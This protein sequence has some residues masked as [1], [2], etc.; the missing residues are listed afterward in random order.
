MT[1]LTDFLQWLY[2][3]L[4]PCLRIVGFGGDANTNHTTGSAY[5][6][7]NDEEYDD[8]DNNNNNNNQQY[9]SS[10]GR[11]SSSSNR[12]TLKLLKLIESQYG[13]VHPTFYM[14]GDFKAVTDEAKRQYKILLV[15]LH[16][17][18][19]Q[20][21]PDFCRN[22]LCTE[23]FRDYV[24][25]HFLFYAA[26]ISSRTGFELG[27]N[28]RATTFPFFAVVYVVQSQVNVV[29]RLEGSNLISDID[30][31]MVRLMEL[32]DN[33][34]P[35]LI[36]QQSEDSM[37][38]ETRS[39][40]EEQDLAYKAA[41]ERDRQVAE[42]KK[43]AELEKQRLEELKQRKLREKMERLER[44]KRERQ[45]MRSELAP[46]PEVASNSVADMR[47]MGVS[48]IKFK[49]PDGSIVQ[50]KFDKNAKV[51]QLY[52]FVHCLDGSSSSSSTWVPSEKCD[53]T[54]YELTLAMPKK[55][56]NPESTLAESD[57][58]PNAQ[59]F[60]RET[61]YDEDEEEEEEGITIAP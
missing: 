50:R 31:V 53:V 48:L 12:E 19:H 25:E 5:T 61:Y 23:A 35:Q 6:T 16:S 18:D 2:S 47:K 13:D 9:S 52:K 58:F 27:T 29:A 22:V 10:S 32:Y 36:V 60:V 33:T 1:S 40:I 43:R 14:G 51:E 26:D 3:F 56:L 46:E 55:L 24:N 11:S 38:H 54:D 15:Y 57:C 41:L 42:E 21:T 4:R 44:I 34:M 30:S 37:R 49:L 17:D 8:I 7:L 20:D 45:R 28:L 39:Q 59:V